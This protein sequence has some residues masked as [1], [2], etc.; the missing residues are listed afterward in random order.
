MTTTWTEGQQVTVH[1]GAG[2]LLGEGEIKVI[3]GD[4]VL[5][6]YQ[7]TRGGRLRR[8]FNVNAVR[9]VAGEPAPLVLLPTR[10]DDEA[11]AVEPA[12]PAVQLSLEAVDLVADQYTANGVQPSMFAEVTR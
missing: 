9:P 12:R 7:T 5:V 1:N 4:T 8:C 2:R 6:D 10:D 3:D 11:P